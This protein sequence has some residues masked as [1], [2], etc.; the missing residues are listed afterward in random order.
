MSKINSE[1]LVIRGDEDP[2]TSLEGLAKLRFIAHKV[3][4]LNVPFAGHAVHLE[5]PAMVLAVVDKFVARK[6]I[7]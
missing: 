4:F 1:M 3:S 7:E 5:D 2:L 6:T